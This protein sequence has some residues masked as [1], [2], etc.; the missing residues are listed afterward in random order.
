MDRKLFLE[1]ESFPV[2]VAMKTIEMTMK[3]LEY[4]VNLVAIGTVF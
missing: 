1:M 4:Y 3:N 2:E